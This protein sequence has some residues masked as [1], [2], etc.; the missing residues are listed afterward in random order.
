MGNTYQENG[1]AQTSRQI[2]T[3]FSQDNRIMNDGAQDNNPQ[4]H[5][6]VCPQISNINDDDPPPY[7]P[8]VTHTNHTAQLPPPLCSEASHPRETT[9]LSAIGDRAVIIG[10]SRSSSPISNGSGSEGSYATK[11]ELRADYKA[12][13]RSEKVV[14]KAEKRE[15]KAEKKAEKK[16]LKAEKKTEKRELKAEK[17][18]EKRELKAEKK[19]EKAMRTGCC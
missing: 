3:V 11:K 19:T 17:K 12:A 9:T 6:K 2:A 18:A 16:E 7:T 15:L 1:L 14:Y 4:N 10:S 13:R 5:S 8:T